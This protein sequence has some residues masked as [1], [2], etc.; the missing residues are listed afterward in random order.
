[1][2]ILPKS[3]SMSPAKANLGLP[4]YCYFDSETFARE[5]RTLWRSTW[6][7]VCR[8][9][10][11]PNAGDYLTYLVGDQ[12]IFVI[13]TANGELQAMHNVC[14]HRGAR[15]LDGQGN[16]TIVRCPYHS[17][18]FNLEGKL[19]GVPQQKRFPDLDKSI[20]HLLPAQVDS[21]GGFI[22][23]NPQTEG[24]SLT[25]YLA[26][27]IDYL[28]QYNQPWEDLREVAR[29]SYE[30]SINWKFIVENY[31]EDYHFSTAHPQSLAFFD[32][33]NIR[34]TTTG[35]HCQIYVPYTA[36]EPPE[37]YQGLR[38]EPRSVSYQGYIFPNLMFNT[39][40]D[41]VSVFRLFALGPTSTRIE[42]LIY[43]TPEQSKASPY[44]E[45]V[46][47]LNFDQVMEEDFA[48]CRLLQAN[49][50]SSAYRVTQLAEERELGIAHFHKVLSEYLP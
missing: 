10:D 21:W 12:P 46:F 5:L 20:V 23:V 11:L 47:R 1:M 37:N 39:A 31:A 22:F 29:W 45:K 28:Q 7:F 43:Q 41:H 42:V 34:T 32:F 33:Q 18:T 44:D 6:Q 15:L 25:S 35:R 13:R 26:G 3:L 49:V 36:E 38:W 8:E 14:P 2:S 4:G 27:F 48:V 40:K 19:L 17:W 24:E 30:E 9:S 16:C 50:H